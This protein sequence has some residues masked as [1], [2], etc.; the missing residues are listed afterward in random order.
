MGTTAASTSP[1][2]S[3]AMPLAEP[4]C[5]LALDGVGVDPF[6]V[7]QQ[8]GQL[9]RDGAFPGERPD[10][11]ILD[12]V[13]RLVLRERVEIVARQRLHGAADDDEIGT[14]RL[15]VDHG[16]E[17]R[18]G[19]RKVARQL[20][21]DRRRSAFSWHD[22]ADLDA[23]LLEEALVDPHEPRHGERLGVVCDRD[24]DLDRIVGIGVAGFGS[25]TT[26]KQ[27]DRDD[28][29]CQGRGQFARG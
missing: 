12:G 14:A 4:A 20:V 28:G 2:S 10:L 22:L 17:A 16:R 18:I 9:L 24:V 7:G 11:H 23:A 8:V 6:G 1:P 15:R 21:L 13:H 5:R 25:R 19:D 26:G 29:T 27:T 3:S